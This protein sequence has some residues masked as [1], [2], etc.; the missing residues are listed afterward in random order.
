MKNINTFDIVEFFN[1]FLLKLQK[2]MI[3]HIIRLQT[4]GN[5]FFSKWTVIWLQ[6]PTF[7]DKER[8]NELREVSYGFQI[9]ENLPGLES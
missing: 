2:E 1:R 3:A 6:I 7:S 8:H 9:L 5:N 4:F